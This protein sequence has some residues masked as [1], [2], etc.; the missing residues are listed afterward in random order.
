MCNCLN[1][2]TV[3]WYTYFYG[4]TGFFWAALHIMCFSV[5]QRSH[6]LDP[7]LYVEA[8]AAI[9]PTTAFVF[10]KFDA[11]V[12]IWFESSVSICIMK[13]LFVSLFMC[14]SQLF[15]KKYFLFVKAPRKMKTA[16][17][18]LFQGNTCTFYYKRALNIFS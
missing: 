4:N 5:K 1:D 3:I 15:W 14:L 16:W 10:W 18:R 11:F 12:P 13:A 6:H 7:H 8:Y 17:V 2:L 9:C